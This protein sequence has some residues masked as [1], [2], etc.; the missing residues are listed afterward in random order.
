MTALLLNRFLGEKPRVRDHLLPE[1]Y[2]SVARNCR[3]D[4]G[5]LRALRGTVPFDKPAKVGTKL[6]LHRWGATAGADAFGEVES[7]SNTNPVAI[8]TKQDHGLTTGQQVF[9]SA[10]GGMMQLND[11]MFTITVTGAKTFTLDGIN[12]IAYGTY[13]SGGTWAKR[14]GYWL[15][16]TTDVN[17]V[18][19]PVAG[20]PYQRVYYTGDGAPK[21]T[22]NPIAV[23]G[24]TSY[25]QASY[26][27]GIPAP[28]TSPTAATVSKTGTIT[29]ATQANPVVITDAGHGLSTGKK[30]AISGVGGMTQLNGNS[31]TITVVDAN[32]FRLDG[33]DG[34][35]YGAYT[36]GGTWTETWDSV[37]LETR[38]YVVTYVSGIGEEGPPCSPTVSIT[39]GPDQQVNLSSI[40]VA[41][42]GNYN[43]TLKRIYRSNG[44]DY[45]FVAELAIATTTYSDTKLAADLGE[46]LPSADWDPPPSDLQGLT[47]LPNGMLAGFRENELYLSEPW[48]PHA[49]PVKYRQSIDYK[50]K[51]LGVF[52]TAIVLATEGLPYIATGID[53]SAVSMDKIEQ[54]LACVSKRSLVDLGDVVVYAAADGLVAVGPGVAK[55]VTES[56][57]T[58]DDWQALKPSSIHAYQVE[59]R[60]IGFYDT[61]SA[62]GGFIFEPRDQSFV[63]LD[64]YATAGFY[65]LTEGALF[66]QVGDRV[67]RWDGA[68]WAKQSYTWESREAVTPLMTFAAARVQADSY[69]ATFELYAD[70]VLKHTETVVDNKPFRLPGGYRARQWKAK[71]SGTATVRSAALVSGID[72]LRGLPL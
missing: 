37:D 60:Y 33:V 25:P 3:L 9:L 12:G 50:I 70:G 17:V 4:N 19:S 42:A 51:A 56:A 58:R 6:S 18:R 52:G 46:A 23:Q 20:D 49:W 14:N 55:I 43:I 29:G 7:A 28:S 35:A 61:G 36:S 57:M 69:P 54:S 13:T 48:Y 5:M 15:H 8:G 67:V 41:P 66:L 31:Y 16:W 62:Q 59:G 45:Q 72:E 21:M 2:A 39:C 65:D 44:G 11:L 24:G 1:G 38:V 27:L 22:Y 32:N 26:L 40:P 71:F 68:E 30:V 63:F 53:P 47:A 34:I 64:T 10:L